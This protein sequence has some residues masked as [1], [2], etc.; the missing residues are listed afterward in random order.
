MGLIMTKEIDYSDACFNKFGCEACQRMRDE[1]F[2]NGGRYTPC[3]D[4]FLSLEEK[5]LKLSKSL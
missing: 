3:R 1:I 5:K 2:R 4:Q